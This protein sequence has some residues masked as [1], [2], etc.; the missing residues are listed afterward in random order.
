MDEIEVELA[1][2]SELRDKPA[3]M[4]R[5]TATEHGAQ[6]AILPALARVLPDY[7]DI[8]VEVAIDYGLTDIVTERFDAGVRAGE[9]VDKDMIAVRIGPDLRMAVVGAPS[10]FASHAAPTTPHHLADHICVNLRLPTQGGLYAWEFRKDGRDLQVRVDGQLTFN[11]PPIMLGAAIEGLGLAFVLED[12]AKAQISDGRLVR[13][14]AEWGQPFAG[15]HLYYPSRRQHT[16][17][18]T[19]LVE[20]MRYRG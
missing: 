2:L 12:Q 6:T 8:N 18:F 13:V 19:L 14:L 5:L 1:A 17:A 20:A 9:R 16:A 11:S 15:Y 3:G 10:Y 4:I 7:P